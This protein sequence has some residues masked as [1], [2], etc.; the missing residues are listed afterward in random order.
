MCTHVTSFIERKA[1]LTPLIMLSSEH[2]PNLEYFPFD[3]RYLASFMC[4]LAAA[5][6]AAQISTVAMQMK[7]KMKFK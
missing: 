1:Q 3:D 7:M 2:V 6:T 5:T 4:V